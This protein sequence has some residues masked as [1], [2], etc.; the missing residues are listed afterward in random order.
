MIGRYAR[1]L[2]LATTCFLNGICRQQ[3]IFYLD[4]GGF[5]EDYVSVTFDVPR[6]Y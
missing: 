5:G 4:M 6:K 3:G 2:L 1:Y